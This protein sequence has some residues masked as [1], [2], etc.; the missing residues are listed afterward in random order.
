MAV[1]SETGR[2]TVPASSRRYTTLTRSAMG[3]KTCAMYRA[4][5]S[6]MADPGRITPPE[7]DSPS[8]KKLR[9]LARVNE[10]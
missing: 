10:E 1:K 4:L 5:Y 6:S 3:H 8:L 9:E 2:R 7:F